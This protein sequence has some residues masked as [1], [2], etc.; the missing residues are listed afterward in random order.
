MKN[1]QVA[2]LVI[3]VGVVSVLSGALLALILAPWLEQ[4]QLIGALFIITLLLLG[5]A[6]VVSPIV[7]AYLA[8][9]TRMTDDLQM[10]ITAN[11]AHRLPV[12]ES[13]GS[14]QPMAEAINSLAEQYQHAL[15]T[16]ATQI[17]QAE[18]KLADEK[19]KLAVLIE[20]LNEWP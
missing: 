18:A 9:P 15:E 4:S 13:P 3:V 8:A 17:Q 6:Y 5:V 14:M 19:N 11:P 10:I 2:T 1:Q 12:K 20:E 7:R 16:G